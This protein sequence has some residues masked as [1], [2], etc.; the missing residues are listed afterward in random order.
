[1]ATFRTARAQ[2]C[3]ERGCRC[4]R[5]RTFGDAGICGRHDDGKPVVK[6]RERRLLL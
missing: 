1:M 3:L 5:H 2:R 6:W 4:S